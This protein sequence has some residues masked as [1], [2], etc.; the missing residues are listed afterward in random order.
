[1]KENATMTPRAYTKEEAKEAF[2]HHVRS[3][4]TYWDKCDCPQNDKLSG[5]AFSILNTFDG[6]AMSLPAMDIVLRPHASDEEFCRR[7]G[8]NW[9]PDGMVINDEVNLHDQLFRK[10]MFES[11]IATDKL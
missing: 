4:V 1:M 6:G 10:T 2:L 5:L 3:L 9:W 7:N 11:K 8:D